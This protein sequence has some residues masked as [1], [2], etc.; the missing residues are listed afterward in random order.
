MLTA[1]L[2]KLVLELV[3]GSP[4]VVQF[5][6]LPRHHLGRRLGAEPLARQFAR[7]SCDLRADLLERLRK[8]GALLVE[9]EDPLQRDDDVDGSSDQPRGVPFP[10]R[11]PCR[12]PCSLTSCTLPSRAI[13]AC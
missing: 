13:V 7:E 11:A 10:A 5:A 1:D 12:A 4:G 9:V 3:L 6:L 2:P 8:P